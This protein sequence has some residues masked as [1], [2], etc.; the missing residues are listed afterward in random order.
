[1]KKG[2]IL[3]IILSLSITLVAQEK[4]I[5]SFISEAQAL[6]AEGKFKKAVNVLKIAIENYP[7]ASN[8]HLQLGLTLGEQGGKASKTGNLFL[9]MKSTNGCF[10][11]MQKAVQLDPQNYD[12]HFYYGVY[13][14]NVPNFFNKLEVGVEH[15]E[16][17]LELLKGSA[18]RSCPT[19]RC[20]CLSTSWRGISATGKD[21]RSKIGMEQGSGIGTPRGNGRG[22]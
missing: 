3:L 19:S 21:R 6:K 1:M 11:E 17:A 13:A 12:A 10:D 22:C 2:L 20:G 14:M 5:E 18:W 9:A 8:A 4:S 16:K 7:D 15:L